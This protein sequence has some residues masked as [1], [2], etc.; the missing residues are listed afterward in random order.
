[1]SDR[2]QS[3]AAAEERFAEVFA[4]VDLIADYA[5]RRRASDPEGIAA[6]VMAI[7]WRRLADVPAD[8]AR[9]WLIVTARNLMLSDWRKQRADGREPRGGLPEV[10]YGPAPRVELDPELESALMRLSPIDRE[11]IL[12]VAWEDLTP[13]AAA[14]ALGISRAAFRVRL[15]RARRRLIRHLAGEWPARSQT[16]RTRLEET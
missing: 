3:R 16:T 6:E 12:L 14:A 15:H 11:A 10:A 4:H 13:Q 9:P 1:M 8:D 5:R 2:W 7:A